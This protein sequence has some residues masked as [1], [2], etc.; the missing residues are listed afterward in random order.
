MCITVIKTMPLHWYNAFHDY[1]WGK[2]RRRDNAFTAHTTHTCTSSYFEGFLRWF[3]GADD[4]EAWSSHAAEAFQVQPFQHRHGRHS[5]VL[6][7]TIQWG[8]AKTEYDELHEDRTGP[9]NKQWFQLMTSL[10]RVKLLNRN[11]FKSLWVCVST[12]R[13]STSAYILFPHNCNSK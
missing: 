1:S 4:N 10:S 2:H 6:P 9:G 7:N 13:S 5:V 11:H 12:F 3:T 8:E